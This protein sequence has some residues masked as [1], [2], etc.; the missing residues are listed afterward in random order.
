MDMT[1]FLQHLIDRGYPVHAVPVDGGWLEIDQTSDLEL[2]RHMDGE[3]KLGSL[4]HAASPA[5]V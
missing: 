4:Y 5:R 3:G 1:T 2:Y